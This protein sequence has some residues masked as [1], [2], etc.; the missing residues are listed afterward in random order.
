MAILDILI[1]LLWCQFLQMWIYV[2]STTIY[3]EN[4]AV[5]L[6][7]KV[8]FAFLL[9]SAGYVCVILLLAFC[10]RLDF[11]L[12]TTHPAVDIQG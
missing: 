9:Y 11:H 7:C 1:E 6:Q 10:C 12:R 2:E 8:S 5:L 4:T 3:V